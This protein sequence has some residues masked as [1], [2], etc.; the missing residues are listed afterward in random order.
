MLPAPAHPKGHALGRAQASWLP[1]WDVHT[2]LRYMK[3][4][5]EKIAGRVWFPAA[6]SGWC[7][8]FNPGRD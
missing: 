1:T 3:R 8:L 5:P 7:L 4:A 2:P 6:V